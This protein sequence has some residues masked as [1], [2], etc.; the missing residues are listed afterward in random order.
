VSDVV[1]VQDV[2]DPAIDLSVG[3]QSVSVGFAQVLV[4]FEKELGR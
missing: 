2:V 1:A 4:N 3:G